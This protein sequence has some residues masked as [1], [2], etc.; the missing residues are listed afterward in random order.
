MPVSDE[1]RRLAR[2]WSG[3]TGWPRRLEWIEIWG[4]RGWSGQRVE[5]PFPIVAIVGENGS[6]KST[7]LQ[8]AACVYRAEGQRQRRYASE[9]FPD[10]AW[11]EIRDATVRCGYIEGDFHRENSIR[12][13]TTRWLGN[14]ERPTRAVEY[15]DLSRIQPVLARVGY[16]KIAKTRHKEAS[17]KSFNSQQVQRLSAVMGRTY[18]AAKMALTDIDEKREVP[19]ISKATTPYSGFHQGSGETTVVE[20]LQADLPRYGLVLIDEIE[21]SLHPRA[22]RR[23]MRDLANKCRE[24]E[25]QIILT[26]HSPYILEELP[27]EARLYI[28]ETQNTKSIVLG[29]SP[30]FAMTKMDD[31]RHP[32]C[33][34]YVEDV[35]AKI[36]LEEILAFHAKEMFP[37]CQIVPF[38]AAS[39]G[40]A[41]GQ[42]VANKRFPRPSCVFLD[43]DNEIGPGCNLLPGEDAPEQ[44]VFK[45]LQKRRFGD[46]WTRISRD[47]SAVEDSCR[48]AMTLGD[49]HD[50]VRFAA[51]QLLC[52]GET[53]WQAMC[54]EWAKKELHSAEA[55]AVV[56]PIEDALS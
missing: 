23:L 3:G 5:F 53:L 56:Q 36:F 38:G 55:S 49:H 15:I 40:Y 30:Q 50:W 27:F 26:T 29:V 45:S 54:A 37:R 17:A 35:A 20:L 9:F 1:V 42:M 10:T 44:I 12:K 41:L 13:P 2:K 11:D 48:N 47:V 19:V 18:D 8:A 24:R 25:V 34:V 52:G 51:N 31:D 6:G 39:V 7:L 16:A 43:G 32:E 14:V 21:L 28:L 22:Q 4:L 46:L 33:D